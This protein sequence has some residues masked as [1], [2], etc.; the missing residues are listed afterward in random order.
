MSM[1]PWCCCRACSVCRI[2]QTVAGLAAVEAALGIVPTS[3]QLAAR[4][5]LVAARSLEQTAWRLLL[6]WPRCV[7]ASPAL[8]TLETIA[9]TVVRPATQAV[10][11][12]DLESHRWRAAGTG[13]RRILPRCSINSSMKSTKWFAATRPAMTGPDRPPSFER[14]LRHVSTPAALTLR[15]LYEQGLADFGCSTVEPL[16]AFDLAVLERRMAAADG[17]AFAPAPIWMAW[18]MKPAPWPG[19]G[20]IR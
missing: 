7:G 15:C 9:A 18:S 6:D 16:P 3:S 14:W 10:P 12:L 11:R 13:S 17:Y 19:C 20:G 1:P 2:A 4:R 5:F 8:D